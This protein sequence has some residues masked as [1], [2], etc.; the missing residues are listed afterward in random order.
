MRKS[1]DKTTVLRGRDLAANLKKQAD[2]TV[3]IETDDMIISLGLLLPFQKSERHIRVA[4]YTN[5]TKNEWTVFDVFKPRIK[6][7]QVLS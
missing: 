5:A 2:A 6:E 4:T 3:A 7:M 1:F